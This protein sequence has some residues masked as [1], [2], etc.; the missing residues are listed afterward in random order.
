MDN[1]GKPSAEDSRSRFRRLLDE[2]EEA[3]G[4]RTDDD[5]ANT[6]AVTQEIKPDEAVTQPIEKSDIDEGQ[7][8]PFVDLPT[9]EMEPAD[10]TSD[11]Q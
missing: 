11:E 6:D 5:L 9:A 7:T 1:P 2:F 4:N 10:V 8:V 3:E